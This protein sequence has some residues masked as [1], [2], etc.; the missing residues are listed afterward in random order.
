MNFF[1]PGGLNPSIIGRTIAL[2]RRIRSAASPQASSSGLASPGIQRELRSRPT[3]H[4]LRPLRRHGRQ[5]LQRQLD[6]SRLQRQPAQALQPTTTNSSLPTPGRMPS[7]TPP[8]CNRRSRRRTATIPGLDRSTSLFD[9]RHRFVFSGVYQTGKAWRQRLRQ[10]GLQRLDVRP[11]ARSCFG[12]SVQHHH[13]QRGQSSAFVAD[14]PAQ[15]DGR[16]GLRH[17]L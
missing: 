4:R 2:G 12:P 7:T 13:R 3:L 15:H 16:S 8:I 11:S 17:G 14:W 5:L 6:L 9:Q 10:Q 1:R